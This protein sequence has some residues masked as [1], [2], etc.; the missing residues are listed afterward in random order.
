ML[1]LELKVF[2]YYLN[3]N[4]P[5]THAKMA[6]IQGNLFVVVVAIVISALYY[7]FVFVTWVPS[8]YK[9]IYLTRTV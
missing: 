3:I 8:L 2:Y 9:G 7:T 6:K 1:S 5:R 4:M